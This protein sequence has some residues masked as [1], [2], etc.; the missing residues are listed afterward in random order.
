LAL[1]SFVFLTSKEVQ[2][3]ALL[4]PEILI[5]IVFVFNF[6]MGKYIG[7]RFREFWRFRRLISG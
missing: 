7:L 6:F 5:L 2:E 3:F 4:N 1:V